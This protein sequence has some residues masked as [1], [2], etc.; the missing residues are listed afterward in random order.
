VWPSRRPPAK[1]QGFAADERVRV[2]QAMKGTRRAPRLK[3]KPK[4]ASRRDLV[5]RAR[6]LLLLGVGMVA[7]CVE[8]ARH[9]RLLSR[10][11]QFGRTMLS[12]L[13]LGLGATLLITTLILAMNQP[14]PNRAFNPEAFSTA[15]SSEQRSA[16]AAVAG[17]T[18][19]PESTAAITRLRIPAIEVDATVVVKGLDGDGRMEAPN[20]PW[21]VAWYDFS[22]QPGMGSNVV[23]AGHVDHQAVG[24]AVFWNLGKLQPD[25]V[26]EVH[27]DDGAVYRYRVIAKDTVDVAT[28]PVRQ[29]VGPTP[30]DSLTLITCAGTFDPTTQRYD[31]RLVVRAER[32]R[33]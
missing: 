11:P 3:L 6:A 5:D 14:A 25:N 12:R 18:R 26:V 30:T 13:L 8:T 23:F 24:P 32:A 29:I 17:P 28:A 31:Q 9:R 10:Q 2:L 16:P 1:R 27:L 33:D 21:D 20:G 19:T 22:A 7:L 15:R 4:R